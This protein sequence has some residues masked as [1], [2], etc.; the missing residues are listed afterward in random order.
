MSTPW[1]AIVGPIVLVFII[2]GIIACCARGRQS[3]DEPRPRRGTFNPAL[4]E[5]YSNGMQG[6]ALKRLQEA[7][8]KDRGEPVWFSSHISHGQSRHWVLLIHDCKY[9]VHRVRYQGL[10]SNQGDPEPETIS[11]GWARVGVGA[12]Q[13][14]YKITPC[15]IDNERV[16]AAITKFANPSAIPG[17]GSGLIGWTQMTKYEIDTIWVSM[18]ANF[19]TYDLLWNNCQHLLRNFAQ[20]IVTDHGQDWNLFLVSSSTTHRKALGGAFLGR[21]TSAATSLERLKAMRPH[22]QG[23]HRENLD[24]NIKACEEYLRKQR[25][26]WASSSP[27]DLADASAGRFT[28]GGDGQEGVFDVPGITLALAELGRDVEHSRGGDGGGGGVA[29]GGGGRN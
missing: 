4:A 2:I 7:S 21:V 9:E 5:T 18:L 24:H 20:L 26:E 25:V 19:G 3:S 23:Y 22:I 29:D 17:I 1:A 15:N 13:Y 11:E 27:I 16:L 28:V 10:A 8:L 6:A 12:A 14:D